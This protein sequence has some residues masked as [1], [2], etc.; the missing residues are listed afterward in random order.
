MSRRID[1]AHSEYLIILRNAQGCTRAADGWTY[2]QSAAFVERRTTSYAAASGE[3]SHVRLVSFPGSWS[4][5]HVCRQRW[6]RGQRRQGR[7][8]Q[9]CYVRHILEVDK[10]RQ[11][12]IFDAVFAADVL[13]LMVEVFRNS[14][15]RT[16]ANPC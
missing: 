11:V 3:A 9:P 10:L 4:A 2:S 12:P 8:I 5:F 13:M 16:A 14:V 15:N 1:R 7:R 6:S